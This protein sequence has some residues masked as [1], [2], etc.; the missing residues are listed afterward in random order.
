MEDGP[1]RTDHTVTTGMETDNEKKILRKCGCG[2]EK[3]TTFRGLRIHQ[4]K[5]RCGGKGHKQPC[6]AASGQ[7]RGTESRVENHSA[8]GPNVAEGREGEEG[9]G[10]LVEKLTS[11]LRTER[12]RKGRGKGNSQEEQDQMAAEGKHGRGMAQ[13]GCGPGQ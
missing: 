10:P 7:T 4:G 8:D 5:A 1:K 11:P 3:V 12:S 6:A 13:I 2:W 9:E